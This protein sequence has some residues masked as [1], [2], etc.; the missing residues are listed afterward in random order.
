LLSD[1][2]VSFTFRVDRV[3]NNDRETTE[4]RMSSSFGAE[5]EETAIALYR[6]ASDFDGFFGKI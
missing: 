5:R 3:R 4:K 2:T 1:T 6:R